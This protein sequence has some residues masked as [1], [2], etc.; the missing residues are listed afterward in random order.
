[1]D[2]VTAIATLQQADPFLAPYIQR[3]GTGRFQ[4]A[5]NQGDILSSL[6]SVIISQQLSTKAAAIIHYTNSLNRNYTM[7]K[8][9]CGGHSPP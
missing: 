6:S 9:G 2:D 7:V 4:Q 8:R 3:I 1:M 5:Q